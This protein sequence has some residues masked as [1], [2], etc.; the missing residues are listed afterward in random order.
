MVYN[1]FQN[2]NIYNY[3]N[4]TANINSVCTAT[5]IKELC[6]T[7]D[8]RDTQLFNARRKLLL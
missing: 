6:G 5:A 7:R 8:V 4:S 3:V 1:T 2:N